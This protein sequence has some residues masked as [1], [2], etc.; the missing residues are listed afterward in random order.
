MAQLDDLY[1]N[2]KRTNTIMLNETQLMIN[3]PMT[4]LLFSTMIVKYI[5]QPHKLMH[6]KACMVDRRSLIF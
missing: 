6:I 2:Y 4:C 3:K 5:V 1:Y